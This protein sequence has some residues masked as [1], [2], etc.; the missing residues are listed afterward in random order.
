[1]SA[2]QARDY[3]DWFVERIPSRLEQF[4]EIVGSS[5]SGSTL[6]YSSES[7][8]AVGEWLDH[9]ICIRAKSPSELSADGRAIPEWAQP[10]VEA[11]CF[12]E[13][14]QSFCVDT[15]IYMGES[16]RQQAP[17]LFWDYVRK[18]RSDV[19]LHQPVIRGF[20]VGIHLNPIRS[21]LVCASLSLEGESAAENLSQIMRRWLGYVG[22]PTR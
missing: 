7:L 11:T 5:T 12:T 19:D 18:P 8:V 1:M 20:S 14:T 21:V 2:K 6:N 22:G 13:E 3:F 9:H 17:Q 4:R 15:G 16:L 10:F